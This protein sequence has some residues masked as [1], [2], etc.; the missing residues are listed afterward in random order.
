[1]RERGER[2]REEAWRWIGLAWENLAGAELRHQHEE[3]PER[4]ACFWAQQAAETAIKA[5]L[6]AEDVDPPR[7]HD[8]VALAQRCAASEIN[9][10]D[11]ARLGA[12]AAWAVGARYEPIGQGASSFEEAVG[13]ARLVVDAAAAA[14]ERT[15]GGDVGD[16]AEEE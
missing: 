6:V 10:L 11:P 3:M 7:S 8:L 15:V 2:L 1:M 14:V 13:I 9:G 16:S 4:H 12:L 5:V